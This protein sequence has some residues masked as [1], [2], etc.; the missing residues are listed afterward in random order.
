VEK[1][2]APAL[3]LGWLRVQPLK[4]CFPVG[5]PQVQGPISE[6]I[7][8]SEFSLKGLSKRTSIDPVMLI[9]LQEFEKFKKRKDPWNVV[10]KISDETTYWASS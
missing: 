6:T 2:T 4:H 10:S 5:L 3:A 1:N 8:P 9:S 7:T